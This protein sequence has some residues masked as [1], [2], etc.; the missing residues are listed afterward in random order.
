MWG[1]SG[2]LWGLV[3][4]KCTLCLAMLS[5]WPHVDSMNWKCYKWGIAYPL[6]RIRFRNKKCFLW[7]HLKITLLFKGSNAVQMKR[8]NEYFKP[9]IFNLGIWYRSTFSLNLEYGIFIFLYLL[10]LFHFPFII[11][12]NSCISVQNSQAIADN[13]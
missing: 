7:E 9:Y 1:I 11:L 13:F 2:D 4:L 8:N 12:R 6:L 5:T 3:I 10:I